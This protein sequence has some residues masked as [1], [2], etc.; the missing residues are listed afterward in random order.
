MDKYKLGD[1]AKISEID[2]IIKRLR[3]LFVEID[4]RTMMLEDYMGNCQNWLSDLN[5][6]LDEIKELL[7]VATEQED[8]NG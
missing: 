7:S 4:V 3:A 5:E 8:Y 6:G 2:D 1:R